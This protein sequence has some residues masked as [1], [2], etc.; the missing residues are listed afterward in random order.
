[1]IKILVSNFNFTNR[2]KKIGIKSIKEVVKRVLKEEGVNNVEVS[3]VLGD[4]GFVQELN[5]LWR[6]VDSPTDVLAFPFKEK[7]MIKDGACLG[8]IAISLDTA[9]QQAKTLGHSLEK[10]LEV[11]LIHGTLHLLGYDHEREKDW[12]KMQQ[13]EKEL[14][15]G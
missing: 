7:G 1:M 5:R 13:R 9:R 4:D 10:E 15:Q 2:G 14:C 3:V 6:G 11:L 8:E 12:L